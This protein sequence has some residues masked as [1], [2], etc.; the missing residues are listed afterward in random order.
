MMV[1][2]HDYVDRYIDTFPF[3]GAIF[4]QKGH[5]LRME[6]TEGLLDQTKGG[7]IQRNTLFPIGGAS[8]SFT[9]AAI[10]ILFDRAI[11]TPQDPI[12]KWI[13]EL[14]APLAHLT[15]HALLT[16]QSGLQDYPVHLDASDFSRPLSRTAW[17]E[18]V[19]M[20][21]P[22]EMN[23]VIR[24]SALGYW[25]LGWVIE[26]ASGQSFGRF[27]EEEILL[28]LGMY[29]TCLDHPSPSHPRRVREYE[30]NGWELEPTPTLDGRNFYPQAGILTSLGDLRIWTEAWSSDRLF[31]S[32]LR[33]C[34][35][36]DLVP[37]GM[38]SSFQAAG[39]GW[40]MDQR[41]QT[42]LH[43]HVAHPWMGN[44][45]IIRMPEQDC[46]VGVMSNFAFQDVDKLADHLVR[47]SL[48]LR[49]PTPRKPIPASDPAVADEW[50][51]T[52]RLG[53]SEL[54]LDRHGKTFLL[55]KG[56]ITQELILTED[57]QFHHAWVDRQYQILRNPMGEL[58]LCGHTLQRQLEIT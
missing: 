22:I 27:L 26:R 50:L 40:T 43:T 4:M 42:A 39:Y 11:L 47:I 30:V 23:D 6:R 19:G 55:R 18:L 1:D 8:Q 56:R 33:R 13:P 34:W 44:C 5:S 20:D 41:Y 21:R 24:P 12:G 9:A 54:T 57:R 58:L 32:A 7:P 17:M 46:V 31:G 3:S 52:Y 53:S 2:L 51:G 49:V 25:L 35:Q 14:R 45:R 29:Q 37:G 48:G 15:L 16:H 10:L 36:G 38:G 28:P